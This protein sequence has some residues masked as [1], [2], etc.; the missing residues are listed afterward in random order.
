MEIDQTF[1]W[2]TTRRLKPGTRD[3]FAR[4]WR[5]TEFPE[6]MLRAIAAFCKERSITCD[7]ALERVMGCGMAACQSCAVS[8]IDESDPAAVRYE[9]C[10]REGPVFDARRVHW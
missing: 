5:P 10:C 1:V 6:G 3:D 9:L 4:A 2:I 7:A 8:V